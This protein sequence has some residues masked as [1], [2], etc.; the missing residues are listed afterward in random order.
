LATGRGI[1]PGHQFPLVV[2]WAA[3]LVWKRIQVGAIVGLAL[4]PL[5]AVFWIG[6]ALPLP[7]VIGLTRL[8]LIELAWKSLYWPAQRSR[9]PQAQE[10]AQPA[11]PRR[12]S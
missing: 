11:S 2:A 3:W 6:F 12:S 10:T 9:F 5:E 4:L 8:A 1:G 7:W